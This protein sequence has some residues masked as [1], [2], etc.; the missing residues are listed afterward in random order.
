MAE[1]E[2]AQEAA[3]SVPDFVY[4]QYEYGWVVPLGV[5]R[6]EKGEKMSQWSIDVHPKLLAGLTPRGGPD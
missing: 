4:E 1:Q 5:V 2:G 6:D 3:A